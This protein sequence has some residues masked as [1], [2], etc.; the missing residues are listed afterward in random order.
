MMIDDHDMA[1]DYDNCDDIDN[2]AND[3]D[4][5]DDD[6]FVHFLDFLFFRFPFFHVLHIFPEFSNLPKKK[7]LFGP[8]SASIP[9]FI[10]LFI[11]PQSGSPCDDQVW[12]IL[13]VGVLRL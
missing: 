9:I 8:P 4:D 12:Y 7:Y 6:F 5:V 2:D 10:I 1:I 11:S 3:A 13:L